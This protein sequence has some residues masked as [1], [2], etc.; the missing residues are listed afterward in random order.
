MK[1]VQG[2]YKMVSFEIKL[3]LINVTPEKTIEEFMNVNR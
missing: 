1:Q 3:L 2:G